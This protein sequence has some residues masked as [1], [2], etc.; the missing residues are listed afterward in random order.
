MDIIA[1]IKILVVEDNPFISKLIASR[2]KANN[3]E[4][5]VAFDGSSALEKV[6]QEKPRLILLD[7]N[8]PGMNGFEVAKKLKENV[9][10]KAIP[11]IFVTA[12]RDQTDIVKGMEFGAATYIFKPFTP[13]RLLQE[14]EN[15]LQKS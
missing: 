7:V 14:I 10:S 8:M 13:E 9:D 12:N 3:F 1:K 11:F 6:Q 15:V 2:L 5:M 4:V